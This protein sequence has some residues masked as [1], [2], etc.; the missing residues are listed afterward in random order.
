MLTT[1]AHIGRLHRAGIPI[2]AGTD[3]SYPAIACTGRSSCVK[4]GFSPWMH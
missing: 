3:Q 1:V 2:V 4:A